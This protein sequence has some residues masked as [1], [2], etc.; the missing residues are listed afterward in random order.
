M[1]NKSIMANARGIVYWLE[2]WGSYND[3]DNIRVDQYQKR[4]FESVFFSSGQQ[5][6]I[7]R[8]FSDFQ[9]VE[10]TNPVLN[11]LS[12]FQTVFSRLAVIDNALYP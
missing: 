1:Q 5:L 12:N 4:A 11:D 2:Y 10:Y 9:M 6:T 7:G 8:A 3:V